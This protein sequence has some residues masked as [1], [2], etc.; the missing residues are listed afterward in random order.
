[1]T[2]REILERLV[3]FPTVSRDSNLA[4]IDWVE[5][6]LASH[7]VSAHR[8]YD[9]T[10]QKASLFANIGPEVAGG[11]LLS[12][13]TDVVPVDGQDWASDPWVVTERDGRLYGRGTCDMKGF[14]ALA[15]AAV[16]LALERDLKRPL[17]IVLTHDEEVGCIGAPLV[18]PH[19]LKTLPKAAAVIVGEPSMMDCVTGHKGGTGFKVHVRGVEIHSSMMHRGVSAVMWAARLIDWGNQENERLWAETPS[20]LA[21]LF[22]PPFTTLHTGMIQGG[23]AHNITAGDCWFDFGYRV[24]P[25]E[26]I[27]AHMARFR[28]KVA[29]LEAQ[30]QAIH[31]DARI[32]VEGRWPV[33][34]LKPETDGAAETLAR[35]I[36]GDNGRHVVSYG[37]EA[38]QFQEAGYSAVVCG[39]GSIDQAHQPDE[40][41]AL[42]QFA[43]GEA[44]VRR[45]VDRLCD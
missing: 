2:A 9:P 28:A 13:H 6:Y 21:A 26:D 36:T 35:S 30:M 14:D 43:R 10:G 40:Y 44:F 29:E 12:G 19:V 7:G 25:G 23:T 1:M 33:P 11:T 41:I 27:E 42:D 17:Q 20:D 3:A 18:I 32:E 24:V 39:P 45:V 16:P 4:L 37:T 22:D 8:V 15:L 34:G 5:D 31:P 38:G